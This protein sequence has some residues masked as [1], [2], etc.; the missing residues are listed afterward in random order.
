M[1]RGETERDREREQVGER[2]TESLPQR[3]VR[4]SFR[5][6]ETRARVGAA[7]GQKGVGAAFDVL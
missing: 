2:S 4:A 3:R 5:E 1:R 7:F 6:K